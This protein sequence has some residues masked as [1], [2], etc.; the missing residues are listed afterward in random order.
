MAD[1]RAK[2]SGKPGNSRRESRGP[3][4][5]GPRELPKR[6]SRAWAAAIAVHMAV[7]VGVFR[8][9]TFGHGLDG[10][11]NWAREDTVEER[12]T[13]VPAPKQDEP[14]KA[15]QEPTVPREDTPKP[16]SGPVVA[17][18]VE[19]T[20]NPVS[21]SAARA[22]TGGSV[23]STSTVPAVGSMP[24]EMRGV[25]PG[26]SDPSIWGSAVASRRSG[27]LR[28]GADRLDSVISVAI[29]TAIDSVE[30][31]A[32]R[33]GEG[34][35]R[36]GDWTRRDRNGDKWGWDEG[37][38][39]LGKVTIPNALLMMLPMNVQQSMSANPT[40][41]DRERRL[42]L[43]RQDIQYNAQ[44]RIGE[45]GF[46]KLVEELRDRKEREYQERQKAKQKPKVIG[47]SGSDK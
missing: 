46:K 24:A 38:I 10:F 36:P 44:S 19:A 28:T 34:G 45:D 13:W 40:S 7:G 9:L 5:L 6:S 37:G 43:A 42:A 26:F 27:S 31:I 25:R 21:V 30:A 33:N 4:R 2:P 29:I 20:S 15:L 39:R 17:T 18:S 8:L 16:I 35:R 3:L 1:T 11:F 32:R 47:Q 12:I 41:V 23:T 14:V 22:D